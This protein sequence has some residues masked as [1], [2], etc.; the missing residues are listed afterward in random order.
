MPDDRIVDNHWTRHADLLV[1][2]YVQAAGPLR[3]ELVTRALAAAIGDDPVDVIDIGGGFGE[4]AIRLARLGHRVTIVDCD[5]PMLEI[6]GDW[7]VCVCVMADVVEIDE[8]FVQHFARLVRSL[9]VAF[10][11]ESAADA[12]QEAF[13]AADR[14]WSTVS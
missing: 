13:I 6:W 7:R 10:D 12:V 2:A 8:L 5:L 1:P 9:S 11:A 4:Q 14:R 3:F